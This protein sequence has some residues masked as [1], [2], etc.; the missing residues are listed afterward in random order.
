MH[1]TPLVPSNYAPIASAKVVILE[2]LFL[3]VGVAQSQPPVI[4]LTQPRAPAP[5]RG[6]RIPE[7][8]VG[9]VGGRRIGPELRIVPLQLRILSSAVSS[10]ATQ[11]DVTVQITNS[12]K[13]AFPLPISSDPATNED[14]KRVRRIGLFHTFVAGPGIGKQIVGKIVASTYC[15]ESDPQSYVTLVPGESRQVRLRSE[16]AAPD[17]VDTSL[18]LSVGYSEWQLADDRYQISAESELIKSAE[19]T[20]RRDGR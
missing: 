6:G 5:T 14:G 17:S 15:S 3:A 16:L 18:K 4:D 7:Y 8:S 1:P 2:A 11:I 13:T 10:D 20:I 12:S 9:A 19:I